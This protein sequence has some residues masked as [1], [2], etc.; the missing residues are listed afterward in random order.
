MQLNVMYLLICNLK[1]SARYNFRVRKITLFLENM[2]ARVLTV[3]PDL[4]IKHS[5]EIK[6]FPI[7]IV[8][9]AG[10]Q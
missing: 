2:L 10:G 1:L 8:R 9:F 3:S 7:N 6:G 5:C 4:I